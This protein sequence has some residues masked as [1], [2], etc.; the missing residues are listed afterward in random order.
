M[1]ENNRN[2]LPKRPEPNLTSK[3]WSLTKSLMRY[4]VEGFPNVSEKVFEKRMLICNSCE[5][6]KR[7]N[8]SCGVCGCAIEYKGRMKTESCPKNKW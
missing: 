3:A 4:A 8:S 7:N 5:F 2:N 6:L 1:D